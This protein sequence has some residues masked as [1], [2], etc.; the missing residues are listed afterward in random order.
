MTE[1]SHRQRLEAVRDHLTARLNVCADSF[2][3][4]ISRQL[5]NVLLELDKADEEPAEP[6]TLDRLAVRRD[7]RLAAAGAEPVTPAPPPG[8]LAQDVRTNG[9]RRKG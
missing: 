6:S 1:P 2:V 9:H 5:T 7:A 4:P 3:G 8:I